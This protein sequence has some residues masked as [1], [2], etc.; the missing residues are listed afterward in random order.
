MKPPGGDWS[1]VIVLAIAGSTA[2]LGAGFLGGYAV[3]YAQHKP[4]PAAS[5]SPPS[6]LAPSAAVTTSASPTAA[7][8]PNTSVPQTP[9]QC[10]Y[11]DFPVYPGSR[12]ANPDPPTDLAWVVDQPA[13]IVASYFQRGAYQTNWKFSVTQ[14]AYNFWLFHFTRAPACRGTLRITNTNGGTYYQA[15]TDPP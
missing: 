12:K 10:D 3:G 4:T 9:P 5:L 8:S 2:L 13:N 7:P 14:Q 11:G 15:S 1:A 6:S